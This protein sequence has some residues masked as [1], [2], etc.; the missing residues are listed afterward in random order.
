MEKAIGIV[1]RPKRQ[2]TL[3]GEI[4]EK[5]DI[6][7]GDKLELVIEGDKLIARPV[8]AVALEALHEIRETFER[9]GITEEELQ[10]AGRRTRKALIRDRYSKEA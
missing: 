4:C 9:Y 2:V 5:L 7:P 1:V 6:R 3:P 10:D 8:K